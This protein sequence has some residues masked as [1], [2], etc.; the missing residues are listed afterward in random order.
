MFKL[1]IQPND[2]LH[3]KFGTAKIVGDYFKITSGKEGNNNKGLHRLIYEDFYDV[4]LPTEIDIHHKDNDKLN[5]CICNLEAL[6]HADHSASHY[7]DNLRI[8]KAGF[9][10]G[11]QVYALKY[12]TKYLKRS[13]DYESLVN[14]LKQMEAEYGS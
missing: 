6:T 12:K 11:K 2:T 13:I 14:E 10:N 5:N 7:D 4:E 3:T 9:Y 8:I 1:E